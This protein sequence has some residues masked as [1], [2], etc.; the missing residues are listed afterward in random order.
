MEILSDTENNAKVRGIV[1]AIFFKFSR[2]PIKNPM[3]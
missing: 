3:P 2:E 1:E